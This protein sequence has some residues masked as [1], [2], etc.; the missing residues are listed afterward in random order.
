MALNSTPYRVR[1]A[2]SDTD[3]G[4]YESPSF[5]I[6]RHP[7]ETELR[8]V[9]RILAYGLWWDERLAFGRG[10]SEVDEPALW[11]HSLD[12]QVEHWIDVGR[13]DID[14]M[15]RAARH[16]PW[17]SV[18]AYGSTP[19]WLDSVLP[20]V[21]Q[22]PGL[23]IALL[24]DAPTEALATDLPRSIDWSLMIADQ[25]LYVGDAEGQHELPLEWVKTR[26]EAGR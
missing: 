1:L 21:A 23:E 22:L 8:M 16:Q 4:V 6:A 2:I 18:L 10:L 14:R 17:A 15:T 25:V 24:P 13:P 26:T 20:K 11:R 7:S 9:A 12:G 5:T 19:I 3:R